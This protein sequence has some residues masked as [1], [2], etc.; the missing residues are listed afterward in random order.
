MIACYVTSILQC[1]D[2]FSTWQRAFIAAYS[3]N[4]YNKSMQQLSA[5]A[6]LPVHEINAQRLKP[7]FPPV[8]EGLLKWW[9]DNY[10]LGKL[11]NN[12]V[13]A[14]PKFPLDL[15]SAYAMFNSNQPRTTN[16]VEAWHSRFHRLIGADH[17]GI[18]RTIVA[19][20][21]E[22]AATDR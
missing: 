20:Q 10:V 8:A 15:W 1:M 18:F 13:R 4:T 5:L 7:L 12:E 16:A 19:F 9:E 3:M 21:R 6:F 22:Q 2:V 17:V 11:G 14:E